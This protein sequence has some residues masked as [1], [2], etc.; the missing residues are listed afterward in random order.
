MKEK[1]FRDAYVASRIKK[2][3]SLQ[4]RTLRNEKGWSQKDL[5]EMTGMAQARISLMENP[6]YGKFN[7]ETLK[8]IA[9]AFDVALIVRFAPFSELISWSENLSPTSFNFL[10]FENEL[11]SLESKHVTAA[12]ASVLSEPLATPKETPEF[13]F[14]G[15]VNEYKP[16]QKSRIFN[17]SG[18]RKWN[19]QTVTRTNEAEILWLTKQDYQ[20]LKYRYQPRF[21]KLETTIS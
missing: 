3:I 4:I 17:E 13:E 19:R 11:T 21:R 9:K 12:T 7:T 10:S 18:Q 16:L 6:D 20:N 2:D 15:S 1:G 8:R 14:L 5:A